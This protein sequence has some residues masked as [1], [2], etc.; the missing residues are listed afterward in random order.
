[1]FDY[2]RPNVLDST[3][4]SN[5]S[6]KQSVEPTTPD[7]QPRLK[8]AG[9]QPTCRSATPNFT[10]DCK[11]DFRITDPRATVLPNT[12]PNAKIFNSFGDYVSAMSVEMKHLQEQGFLVATSVVVVTQET[13]IQ[14]LLLQSEDLSV[15][16]SAVEALSRCRTTIKR[17]KTR[18]AKLG[19]TDK[20]LDGVLVE[21]DEELANATSRTSSPTEHGADDLP[22]LVK[23]NGS[24][25][26][27]GPS[28]CVPGE[29]SPP[30]FEQTSMDWGEDA[31]IQ[32]CSPVRERQG[33]RRSNN[34][35]G[36]YSLRPVFFSF[37]LL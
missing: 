26:E 10:A 5:E 19:C 33:R 16:Q 3:T 35:L 28:S 23:D 20:F 13:R 32:V 24:G 37:K 36:F 21:I 15:R 27:Q 25:S 9:F 14:R 2:Y 11:P 12:M 17:L 8:T 31:G 6:P 29:S 7:R 18:Q 22:W 30:D 4:A 34:K 1:M